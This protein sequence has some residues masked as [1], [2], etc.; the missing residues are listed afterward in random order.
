M[1]DTT[2][3]FA[4]GDKVVVMVDGF[5]CPQYVSFFNENGK[6]ELAEKF[7]E[8]EDVPVN[9]IGTV[10]LTGIGTGSND[11]TYA[12]EIGGKNYVVGELALFGA[13]EEADP[14]EIERRNAEGIRGAKL[15]FLEDAKGNPMMLLLGMLAGVIGE[16]D[17]ED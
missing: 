8:D 9:T 2:F 3:K 17:L 13:L 1:S 4:V 12:V 14:A 10:I 6:P 7:T 11:N 16:S 15:R 5:Q